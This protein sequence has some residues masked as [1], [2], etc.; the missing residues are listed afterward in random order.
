MDTQGRTPTQGPSTPARPRRASSGVIARTAIFTAF[1][2]AVTMALAIYIPATKGYFD[3]GEV[4][5]YIVAMLM[6][7]YVGAF[8]GGAG[9]AI[10]DAILA[11]VY[12]PGTLAI[13]GLEGFIVGYLT[14]KTPAALTRRAW[15]FTGVVLG[16]VLGFIVALIGIMFLSGQK[17]IYLGF[18]YCSANCTTIANQAYT[19]IGPQFAA[20]FFVPSA[21]WILLGAV[22]FFTV[23]YAALR[24]EE[25]LGWTILSIL[26]GGS[27][28][29]LGYFLY[30]SLAL[31]L[32]FVTAS[33]E[34]PINIGQVLIGLLV[35]V[36]V[37]RSYR[38]MVRRIPQGN[39]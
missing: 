25:R 24:T 26:L 2:A 13:K 20:D 33:V 7:P 23:A 22:V 3:I 38:R 31:Q 17:T 34:V 11:P 21:L 6:G 15:R 28:M 18:S 8:A 1:V 12:A 14:T 35:S 30:E 19:D 10:S 4:M 29:V 5:V 27:E 37:V 39:R 36:P 16:G 32:G 9:S